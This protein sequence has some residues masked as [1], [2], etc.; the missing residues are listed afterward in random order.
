MCQ[1]CSKVRCK[2]FGIVAGTKTYMSESCGEQVCYEE[3]PTGGRKMLYL[4]D[5]WSTFPG[6][7]KKLAGASLRRV[8]RFFAWLE[9]GL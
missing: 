5:N 9:E 3:Q 7:I 6:F 2:V 1:T 8:K 4:G